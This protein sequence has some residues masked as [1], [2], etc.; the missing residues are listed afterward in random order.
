MTWTSFQFNEIAR[1]RSAL[2]RTAKAQEEANR[3]NLWEYYT[4]AEGDDSRFCRKCGKSWWHD[5]DG[6]WTD[7]EDNDPGCPSCR[8][9]Q[10][11]EER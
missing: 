8:A 2:E 9:S 3:V 10:G 11:E 4:D 1:I 5:Y 6:K 7:H